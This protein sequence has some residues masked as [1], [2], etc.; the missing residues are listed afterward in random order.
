M[1]SIA[2]V[3]S[4]TGFSGLDDV[5]MRTCFAS[6]RSRRIRSRLLRAHG[7]ERKRC[8]SREAAYM[9]NA[10]QP[11]STCGGSVDVQSPAFKVNNAERLVHDGAA[12]RGD[13]HEP[14]A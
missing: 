14:S 1:P 7:D 11:S 5:C 9:V 2:M 10:S 6:S 3:R 8:Y 12:L 4:R 13:T